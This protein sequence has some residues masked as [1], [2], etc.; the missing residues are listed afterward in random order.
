MTPNTA[1]PPKT[2]EFTVPRRRAA[3]PDS[4][5][6]SSFEQPIKTAVTAETRPIISGGTLVCRM[7]CRMMTFT[8][9]AA[10]EINKK[11]KEKMKAA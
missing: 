5:M 4:A 9:S 1:R 11:R 3:R 10:P 8:A 7:V 2:T 6:P